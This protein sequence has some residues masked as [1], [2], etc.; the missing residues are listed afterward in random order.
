MSFVFLK[1]LLLLLRLTINKH[2]QIRGGKKGFTRFEM[3]KGASAVGKRSPLPQRARG[4]KHPISPGAAYR[5][6]STNSE[7]PYWRRG[8]IL[9]EDPLEL[10]GVPLQIIRTGLHPSL[11]CLYRCGLGCARFTG[12]LAAVAEH[13]RGA[14]MLLRVSFPKVWIVKS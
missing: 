8:V 14:F 3:V 7:S 13:E 12:T 6:A 2:S 11:G 9:L 5:A 10:F 4:K 1:V